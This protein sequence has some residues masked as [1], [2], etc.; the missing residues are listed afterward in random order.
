MLRK[1]FLIFIAFWLPVQA[2]A[3]L[4]SSVASGMAPPH[5]HERADA[6]AAHGHDGM[7][8]HGGPA[9]HANDD[10]TVQHD[11]HEHD[12]SG[13]CERC[14]LC[15]FVHGGVMLN[16]GASLPA[17][18][19]RHAFAALGDEPFIAHIPELLQRPPLSAA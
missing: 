5:A 12:A 14:G 17:M 4:A 15:Q 19:P 13:G 3:A 10:G 6:A 16:A 8:H 9:T 11:G 1:L 2:G 7:D 18:P